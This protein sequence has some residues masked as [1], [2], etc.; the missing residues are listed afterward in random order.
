M[1]KHYYKSITSK[2]KL[3]ISLLLLTA[4]STLSSCGHNI[5]DF[6]VDIDKFQLN[7]TVLV[8]GETVEILGMSG[9]IPTGV[10]ID[11]YNLVVVR[12]LENGDTVNVLCTA[13]FEIIG[14]VRR[15]KFHGE[16]SEIT[17]VLMNALKN[18]DFRELVPGQEIDTNTFKNYSFGRVMWDTEYIQIDVM[19]YPSIIG[20]LG[21]DQD[22]IRGYGYGEID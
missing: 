7:D 4:V 1:T 12:S 14:G 9:N 19:Q 15:M 5:E 10:E 21:Y 13:D 11:F 22:D 8:D 2:I 18:E 17:K 3:G 6:M 20:S 16:N